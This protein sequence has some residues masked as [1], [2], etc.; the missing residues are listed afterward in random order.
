M[1]GSLALPAGVTLPSPAA[2]D[3][4]ISAGLGMTGFPQGSGSAPSN[5]LFSAMAPSLVPSSTAPVSSILSAAAAGQATG[6]AV[7]PLPIVGTQVNAARLPMASVAGAA[8]VL[9]TGQGS[10]SPL[11]S[12][13]AAQTS[14][15][16]GTAASSSAGAAAD[17][18]QSGD[19]GNRARR[20]SARK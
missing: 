14:A 8:S 19:S 13:T 15:P 7:G 17:E 12:S 5:P 10:L 11:V 3:I 1:G 2:G 9:S 4:A 20:S 18:Q 6:A 16:S